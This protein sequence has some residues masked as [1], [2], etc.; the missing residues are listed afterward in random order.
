MLDPD[1]EPFVESFDEPLQDVSANPSAPMAQRTVAAVVRGVRRIARVCPVAV[2]RDVCRWCR[3]AH[4]YPRGVRF[5]CVLV[6]VA[7]AGSALAVAAC[8]ADGDVSGSG[9]VDH[10]ALTLPPTSATTTLTSTSTTTSTV[11]PTTIAAA[12]RLEVSTTAPPT[13]TTAAPSPASALAG[14]V[15]VIDPGHNGANGANPSVINQLVDVITERKACDTSGTETNGGYSEHEYTFDVATRVRDLLAAQGVRVEL[16]RPD[17]AGVG[18][19]ITERAAIGNRAGADLAVSIHADG[20]PAGGR[21]FHVIRPASLPGH[22]DGIV[23]DSDRFADLL[24]SAFRGTGMPPATYIGSGGLDRR[25][26]L[27]GLNLST[28]P[29][30]FIETGNM[31]NATDA[32]LLGDPGWRQRA[33]S[34]IAFAIGAYLAATPR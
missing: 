18:P 2:V 17:D 28:V 12:E 25:S 1:D 5:R 24:V 31:R 32:A 34:A 30:V 9:P 4:H 8:G 21:G 33:A 13:P 3:R 16:T 26:D 20:G 15:V 23:A 14:R 22:T 19:C 6:L 7:L 10:T 27:G 29:K 11:A